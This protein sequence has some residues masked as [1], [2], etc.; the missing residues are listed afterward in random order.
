MKK[1]Y[2]VS[3]IEFIKLVF[4]DVITTSGEGSGDPGTIPSDPLQGDYDPNGWT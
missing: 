1:E 4:G 3:E 2:V